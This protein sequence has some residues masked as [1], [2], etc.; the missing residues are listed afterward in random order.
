[1][2]HRQLHELGPMKWHV[3]SLVKSPLVIVL[4]DQHH[5]F[6]AVHHNLKVSLLRKIEP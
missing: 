6:C 5:E 2:A 1:M 4:L 3:R